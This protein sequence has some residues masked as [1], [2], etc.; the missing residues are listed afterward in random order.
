MGGND[1]MIYDH[2]FFYDVKIVWIKLVQT[3]QAIGAESIN[4]NLQKA[5]L[6]FI[7]NTQHKHESIHRK[8]NTL[9][10][11]LQVYSSPLHGRRDSCRFAVY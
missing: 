1:S 6:N 11:T 9:E 10:F 4:K 7:V 3:R 8:R 5:V 2:E